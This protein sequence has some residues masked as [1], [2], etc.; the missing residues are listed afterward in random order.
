MV[1][2]PHRVDLGAA[3]GKLTGGGEAGG[4][5][6]GN[7][8]ALSADGSRGLVGGSLDNDHVGAAW[9]FSGADTT[10]PTAPVVV[11]PVFGPAT[12]VP[13]RPVVGKK[14]VFT[15]AVNRSDTGEPLTTGKMICDPSVA[16]VM[17]K[18]AESFT[19]GKARLSFVVPKAAKGKLLKVKVKITTGTR[20]A[21]K[22]VTYKVT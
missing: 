12:T 10:A 20:S 22:V 4:G 5:G 14:L 8:V 1:V 11:K 2:H 9:V 13:P 6:F 7:D 21:T 17:L 16:G 18:H 3:G 19:N 15:L